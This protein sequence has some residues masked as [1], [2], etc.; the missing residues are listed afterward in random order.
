MSK[1]WE[2]H[3]NKIKLAGWLIDE[4]WL[5]TSQDALRF[6]EKPWKWDA[7]WD[8]MNLPEPDDVDRTCEKCDGYGWVD[9][10]EAVPN[11]RSYTITCPDCQGSG[12]DQPTEEQLGLDDPEDWVKREPDGVPSIAELYME[13][14]H[15]DAD[16]DLRPT[17]LIL[18]TDPGWIDP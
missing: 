17:D 14:R 9:T 10:D 6:F 16:E 7:E 18:A 8:Q 15:E 11:S 12:M 13:E 2:N 4:G 1:W 5:V 3:N